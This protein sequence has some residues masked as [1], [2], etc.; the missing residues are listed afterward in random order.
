MSSLASAAPAAHIARSGKSA[1]AAVGPAWAAAA[2]C[3]ALR[4]AESVLARPALLPL[5]AHEVVR[6]VHAPALLFDATC[7]AQPGG[8]LMCTTGSC[9]NKPARVLAQLH[10]KTQ[11]TVPV[12]AAAATSRIVAVDIT[13]AAF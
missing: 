3:T 4:C 8:A 1:S 6:A 2:V 13:V 11:S 5:R 9:V 12:Y 7:A 10:I